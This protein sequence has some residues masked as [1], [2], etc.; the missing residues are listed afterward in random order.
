MEQLQDLERLFNPASLA[1]IG[2]S[3]NIEKSGGQF[4]KSIIDSGYPGKLY[5]VN[6]NETE[7]MGLKSYPTVLDIPGE[8][9]AAIVMVPAP[10]VPEVIAQ[11][12]KKGVK[13]AVVHSAGFAELGAEGKQLQERM[14]A[15]ARQGGIRLIGPNCM[16]FYSPRARINT[17]TPR[18]R[19][20][21]ET[22]PVAFVGQSGWV[23]ENFL[24]MGYDRGLRFSQVVSIGNQSDLSIEDMVE[25]FACDSRTRVIACYIEGIRDARRFL[26]LTRRISYRKP[27][28][29]W[30]V[31]RSNVGARAAVSHTGSLAGNVTVFDAALAQSGGVK[32]GSLDE[33]VDLSVGFS[34][35]VLPPGRR[36]GL[37]VEAGGGAVSGS[38]AAE[39]YGLDVPVFPDAIQREL[40]AKLRGVLPPFSLPRN[41]VDMVWAPKEH[42]VRLF[43]ECARIILSVVDSLVIVSYEVDEPAMIE[44]LAKVRDEAGKPIFVIPGHPIEF[45]D[46]MATL[47]RHGLPSFITPEKAIRTLSAMLKHAGYRSAGTL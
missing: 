28:I 16:G 1:L 21:D 7:I 38:D 19:L 45:H 33:L 24:Q 26:A 27:V 22:G 40:V 6:P 8:V 10:L 12:V 35:P 18:T 36:L 17:I 41:P 46:H 9:E 13:Y 23:T 32:A 43:V 34:S 39:A 30:K 2:A 25:Y 20:G 4:I 44:G 29:V 37:L 5:A 31:G 15:V 11:L 3:N 42:A 14:L 47:T